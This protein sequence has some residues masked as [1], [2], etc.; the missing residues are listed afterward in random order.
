MTADQYVTKYHSLAVPEYKVSNNQASA[1]TVKS[2]PVD[3][4]LNARLSNRAGYTP[5]QRKKFRK[6]VWELLQEHADL[7]DT[8]VYRIGSGFTIA[9]AMW[10]CAYVDADMWASSFTGKGSPE[11]VMAAIQVLSYWRGW[12]VLEGDVPSLT[13]LVDMFLG[14]DCNGFVGNYMSTK[15]KK[16]GFKLGPSSPE[17]DYFYNRHTI[18]DAAS[19]VRADDIV[20]M[21]RTA[22]A[23]KGER[24]MDWDKGS[25]SDM[26]KELSEQRFL[27]G[28]I[29]VISSVT[30][31]GGNDVQV[32]ISESATSSVENGGPQTRAFTL[33]RLGTYRWK[34]V[35]RDSE[36]HSV[37]KV[38]RTD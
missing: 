2:T 15:Y 25:R 24:A 10:P 30:P 23:S 34:I 27:I 3:E 14:T 36:V 20:L 29:M 8:P 4:Y 9:N 21:N 12:R 26:E 11:T 33:R 6:G 5:E 16:N 22:K 17:E 7:P 1:W 31:A 18:R 35:G 13:R 19:E 37:I 28:H 38:K 32:M